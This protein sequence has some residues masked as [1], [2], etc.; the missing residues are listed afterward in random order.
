MKRKYAPPEPGLHNLLPEIKV[1]VLKFL[2]TRSK[3]ALS[4]TNCDWRD[5]ILHLPDAKEIT[6]TLFRLDKK[7][8]HQAIVQMMSGRITASSMA[9]LFEELLSL[10][11]PSAYVFLIFFTTKRYVVLIEI[12]SV[13]L[14]LAAITSLVH[15]LVDYFIESDTKAKKQY[16]HRCAFQFFAQPNQSISQRNSEEEEEEEEENLSADSKDFPM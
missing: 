7:R 13:I 14:M 5:L 6:N 11:I 1:I 3:L 8:H 15:D 16:A 2:D 12:L 4:Q 10:G 9:K